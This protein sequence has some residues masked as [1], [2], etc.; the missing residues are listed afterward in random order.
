MEEVHIW[1]LERVNIK[2]R[3]NF[4]EEMN[5]K[6]FLK[7]KTKP[8]AYRGIF[9]DK[10]IPFSTFKNLLKKSYMMDFFVPLEIYLKIVKG[11][12]ISKYLLERKIIAYKTAGGVNFIENPILPIKIS[13]IFD[14]VLAH[15]ISDGTVIN[16]KK[17]RLPYFG[18]RQFDK[19]YRRL[20]IKKI[21]NVFGKIKFKEEYF[22]N[23]TRPYCPPVL[24][25]L[26]FKYYNLGTEGF[27]SKSARM[28]KKV[29]EKGKEYLLSVLIAFII[30]EGHIDSTQIT[31]ALKNKPLISDLQKI[32]NKLGYGPKITYRRGEYEDYGYLNI[33]R[34]D[35]KKFYEDYLSLLKIYPVIDLGWKGRKIKDS[36]KIFQRKIYKTKGNRNVIFEILK[37][38]QLT[39]NQLA[40]LLCMTRQGIRFH[41]HNLLKEKKIKIIDKND[42]NWLYGV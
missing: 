12:E 34:K 33:L 38:E 13:P 11:L 22:N 21:E 27:L 40:T 24:S 29:L 7:F 5:K 14:M 3:L 2:L 9:K 20:Y 17:G 23:S 8:K 39:V 16:P 30:D 36:F 4:L 19:S 6:I 42:P 37:K 10:E 18:Y 41:I 32:C 26:F 31:I 1:E 35:M 25:S 15:N 28:P